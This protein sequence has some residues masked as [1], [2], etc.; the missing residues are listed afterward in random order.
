ML[1]VSGLVLTTTACS[2]SPSHPAD[3][4]GCSDCKPAPPLGGSS[5]DATSDATSEATCGSLAALSSVCSSCA[6]KGCCGEVAACSAS[7]A[8]TTLLGC[9][10]ACQDSTCVANCRAQTTSGTAPYDAL[11]TCL[12]TFCSAECAAPD[13]GVTCGDLSAQST[14]CGICVGQSCCSEDRTCT[15][16]PACLTI[17]RCAAA[18]QTSDTT[19]VSVCE[20]QDT[21]GALLYN[22]LSQCMTTSCTASCR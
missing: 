17:S 15:S 14:A 5:S 6:T 7:T 1:L 4:A 21:N 18:C 2:I 12:T 19:C 11:S 13:A 10:R 3:L 16:D 20:L 9:A 8:C 22:S